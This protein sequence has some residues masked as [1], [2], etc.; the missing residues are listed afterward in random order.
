MM[1]TRFPRSGPALFNLP[2]FCKTVN[3]VVHSKK[4]ALRDIAKESGVSTATILRVGSGKGPDVESFMR[5]CKW[6]GIPMA[7]FSNEEPNP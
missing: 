7:V 4:K 5:L 3:M 1:K 6:M 2:L